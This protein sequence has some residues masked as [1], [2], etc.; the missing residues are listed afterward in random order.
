MRTQRERAAQIISRSLEVTSKFDMFNKLIKMYD[1]LS[2]GN[3]KQLVEYMLNELGYT[4]CISGA[5]VL[6]KDEQE[7]LREQER[8]FP[9]LFVE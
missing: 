2:P 5:W 6:L 8:M 4:H 7:K 9:G 1:T 3:D